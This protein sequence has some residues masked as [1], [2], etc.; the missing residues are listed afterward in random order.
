MESVQANCVKEWS[1]STTRKYADPFNEVEVDVVFT[2]P[3]GRERRIPAFWAGGGTWRARHASPLVGTHHYRTVCSDTANPDLHGLQGSLQVTPYE[4]DNPLLRHGPLKVATDRRHLEH[5]DGTPFFWLGD[6]WWMGLCKRILWPDEFQ[7]LASDRVSKGFTII[8][9]VAGLSPDMVPFDERGANEAGWPWEKD[10]ARINPAYF[11]LADHRIR[12]LVREGLVPCILGCWGYYLKFLGVKRMKQHWRHIVAR[13]GAY[14]TVWCLAGEG[15]MPFYLS[16]TREQDQADQIASWTKVARYVRQI[17][18]CCRPITI[19]P[20]QRGRDQVEDPSVLDFEMLQTGHDG[21]RSVPNNFKELA[22]A[23][24]REPVMPVVIGEVNYE[25]LLHGTQDEIQR[26]LFW[27]N[28]LSGAAGHTY[29]ANGIWQLNRR[30]QPYGPSPHGGVW[31]NLPWEDAYRLP[32]STQIGLARRFLERYPWWRFENHPEWIEQPRN[33]E[34]GW[35]PFVAGIPGKVRIVYTYHG[36]PWMRLKLLKGI[37]P[38]ICYTAFWLDPRT[39]E[40]HAIGKIEVAPDGTWPVPMS[41]TMDD[42]VL[43]V[44][45]RVLGNSRSLT[46]RRPGER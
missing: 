39:G 32:G 44:E 36:Q 21:H 30:G 18:P 11:D 43:I 13:W 7:I 20:T 27:G 46:G 26:I 23:V 16:Q 34:E 42:W 45:N 35:G 12:W 38:N 3:Q 2:D 24:Q 1:W 22:A 17:D 14:P 41:P 9:I 28:M 29:G 4:G 31:G 25:G 33:V 5:A 40:E 19:H 37:E 6:T 15:A 10:F 8:Q